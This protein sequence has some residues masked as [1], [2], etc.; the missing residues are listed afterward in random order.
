VPVI[1]VIASAVALHEPL[2][3]GQIAALLFTLGG[4]VLATRS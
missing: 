2:G 4:V 3:I 1:G